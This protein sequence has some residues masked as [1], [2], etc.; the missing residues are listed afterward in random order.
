MG[1][2]EKSGS[3]LE[4]SVGLFERVASILEH[5]FGSYARGDWVEDRY[6]HEGRV[7]EYA[8]EEARQRFLLLKRAYTEARYERGYRIAKED[9]DDLSDRVRRLQEAT[10]T[11]CAERIAQY[12]QDALAYEKSR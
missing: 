12:A 3:K 2:L 1:K 5:A 6:E 7:Y 9:L 8:S 4:K 10:K 11:L